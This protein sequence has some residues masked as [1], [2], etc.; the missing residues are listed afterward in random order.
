MTINQPGSIQPAPGGGEPQRP[1]TTPEEAAK[2]FE[3]I[4]VRQFVAAMTEN[5]FKSGLEG[6]DGPGW[7]K[8]QQDTQRDV[9]TDVLTQHLVESKALRISELL[10]RRWQGG[11]AADPSAERA[12]EE[13]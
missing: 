6:D 5:L 12:P 10:V 1:A 8:G 3:A 2:Q 11:T 13:S 9:M 7:M 4:L